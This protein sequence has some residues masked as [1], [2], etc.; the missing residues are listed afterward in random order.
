MTR[1]GLEKE[2]SSLFQYEYKDKSVSNLCCCCYCTTDKIDKG[3][4]GNGNKNDMGNLFGLLSESCREY[5]CVPVYYA[6]AVPV[7]LLL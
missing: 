3:N 1:D 7:A 2:Q 4:E 6:Y 5:I